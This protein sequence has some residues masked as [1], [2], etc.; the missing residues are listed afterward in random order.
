VLGTNTRQ[1]W[2][3]RDVYRISMQGD[4]GRSVDRRLVL[5]IAVGQD[6]LQAR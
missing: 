2:K 3:I 4:A 5:A 6:A 1:M